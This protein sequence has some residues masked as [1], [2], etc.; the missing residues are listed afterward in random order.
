MLSLLHRYALRE[1]LRSFILA[2]FTLASIMLLGALFKPLKMGLGISDVAG[3]LPYLLPYSLAWVIPA[4]LLTACVMAYGRLSA[5]NELLAVCASGVP[6]RYMCYPAFVLAIALTGFT[7]P[8]SDT[9]IPRCR[10]SMKS[11]LRE[12]HLPE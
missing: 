12:A 3:L 5:E 6:L 2:F 11:V 7:L 9:I 4:A 10:S 1:L 8:L